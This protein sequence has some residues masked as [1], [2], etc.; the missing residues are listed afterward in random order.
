MRKLKLESHY[1][2]YTEAEGADPRAPYEIIGK[3]Q[4]TA[5]Y[6][7]TDVAAQDSDG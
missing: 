5:F 1:R 6:E 7:Y 3:G 2:P 4:C